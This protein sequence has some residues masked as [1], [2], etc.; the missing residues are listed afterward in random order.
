MGNRKRIKVVIEEII[1]NELYTANCCSDNARK[2]YEYSNDLFIELWID[3]HCSLRQV[4]RIGID[5]H[6]LQDLAI[7]SVS[8][9]IYYQLREVKFNIIQYPEYKG[10]DKRVVIQEATSTG[11]LL[12]IVIECHFLDI[13]SYEVTLITAMVENNF[14]VF[15][16]QYSLKI[17][18]ESSELYRKVSNNFIKI[19]DFG[20]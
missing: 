8:H 19:R 15:D 4:E 7:R 10:K 3:K 2:F 1:D 17:D 5:L 12:N 13:S 11:D 14:R 16:G 20:I 9:L 18:G 6:I